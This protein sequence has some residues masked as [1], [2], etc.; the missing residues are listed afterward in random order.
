MNVYNV[1]FD[2]ENY[3]LLV[4]NN[5]ADLDGENLWIN[6]TSK[7]KNWK[8]PLMRYAAKQNIEKVADI[9]Q[10]TP[11]FFAFNSKALAA[12]A[13]LLN[14]HG[15]LFELTV[16]GKTL[17]A[18]NPNNEI[19]CFN[20]NASEWNVRRNRKR[21]RLIRP[22]FDHS[23][24][25][26]STIFQVPEYIQNTFYVNEDFKQTYDKS[27]LSGLIFELCLLV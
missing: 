24:I 7:A 19:N 11:G 14:K 4:P 23:K 2:V 26:N 5:D 17:F 22:A 27:G 18:F 25:K 20:A 8:E 13:K 1:T 12:L 3:R 9:T 10:I 16:E 21:G 15:E 6:G